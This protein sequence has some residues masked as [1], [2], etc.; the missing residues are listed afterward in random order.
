MD[1]EWNDMFAITF[2]DIFNHRSESKGRLAIIGL[3]SSNRK[4]GG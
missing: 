2:Q 4:V 3:E 1:W